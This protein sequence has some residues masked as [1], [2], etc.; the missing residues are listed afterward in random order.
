M[1]DHEIVLSRKWDVGWTSLPWD[2][3][4]QLLDSPVQSSPW[5]SLAAL[6]KMD[7][8]PI[9]NVGSRRP[10]HHPRCLPGSY[11][12]PLALFDVLETQT[13]PT[14]WPSPNNHCHISAA[15][16]QRVLNHGSPGLHSSASG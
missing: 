3:A 5:G 6:G 11:H 1:C 12:S 4:A 16:R 10:V 8:L 14:L 13:K 15:G 9:L 7:L 2:W